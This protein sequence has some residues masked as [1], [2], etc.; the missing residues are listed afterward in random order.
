MVTTHVKII[1]Q[2]TTHTTHITVHTTLTN[3]KLHQGG[4][5]LAQEL[6]DLLTHPGG[7]H[8]LDH[9]VGREHGPLQ[10]VREQLVAVIVC[11]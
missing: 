11:V 2:H 3:N 1:A 7:H 6:D 10:R 8:L 5:L 9:V 4:L